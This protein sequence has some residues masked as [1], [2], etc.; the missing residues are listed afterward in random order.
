MYFRV[1]SESK[2]ALWLSSWLRR[3]AMV[4]LLGTQQHTSIR[5]S[6]NCLYGDIRHI[7]LNTTALGAS[8]MHCNPRKPFCRTQLCT[9]NQ[10]M[11]IET[12]VNNTRSNQLDR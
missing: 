3:L 11:W 8:G 4:M 1:C 10:V 6:F 7:H 5:H 12:N 2:V 9:A